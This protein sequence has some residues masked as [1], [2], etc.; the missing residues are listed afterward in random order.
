M[1]V[2]SHGRE[3]Y[4]QRTATVRAWACDHRDPDCSVAR[5][6]GGSLPCPENGNSKP[7]NRL[8]HHS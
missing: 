3:S 5:Q 7:R 1:R 6:P 2:E 8:E 4:V